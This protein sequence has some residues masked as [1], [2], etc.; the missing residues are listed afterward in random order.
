MDYSVRVTDLAIIMATFMGPVFAVWAQKKLDRSRAQR[1]AREKVF[2]V[3]M[4]TRATWI[5]PARVEALNMIPIVFYGNKGALKG[6]GDAH[7]ALLHH[8]SQTQSEDEWQQKA[9][10]SKRLDLDVKL[11]RLIGRHLGY[12]FPELDLETQHYF[13]VGL[14]DRIVDEESIRRGLARILSGKAALPIL[15]TVPDKVFEENNA[16]RSAL[17]KILDGEQALPVFVKSHADSHDV[18]GGIRK[19]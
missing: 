15:H 3:L 14:T 6:I 17:A 19:L 18:K 16:L 10:Q 12:E 8:F 5:S 11:L 4:S 1:D 2:N 13:P 7:R 9:W